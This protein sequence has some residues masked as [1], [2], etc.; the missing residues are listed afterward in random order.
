MAKGDTKK[1]ESEREERN[2]QF[3]FLKNNREKRQQ[4]AGKAIIYRDFNADKRLGLP[5]QEVGQ[6][7][8]ADKDEE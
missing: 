4:N 3:L 8:G 5:A 7:D 6:D 1:K 2:L